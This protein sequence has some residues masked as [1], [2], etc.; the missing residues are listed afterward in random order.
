MNRISWQS[1]GILAAAVISA[2]PALANPAAGHVSSGTANI[3]LEGTLLT[4][5]QD[6]ARAIIDWG[7]FNIGSGETTVFEFNHTAGAGSAVLNRVSSGS[8]SIIDGI[9]RSTVGPNGPVGGTVMLLNPSGILFTPNAQVSVGN[10]VA[11]TLGLAESDFI[12][13]TTLHFSGSTAGIQNQGHLAAQGDI[14]LIAH[15]VQNSGSINAGGAAGLAAGTTVTLAQ[16]GNERLT[17]EAGTGNLTPIG[18]D[19][20]ASGQINAVAAELKAAGGNI[21]ALAINNGGIVRATSLVSQNGRISLRATDSANVT[22]GVVSS[23]GTLD[24]TGPRGADISVEGAS[25][26]LGGVVNAGDGAVDLTTAGNVTQA[27]D[28]HVTAAT[29]AI[30]PSWDASHF[31]LWLTIGA[32]ITVPGVFY[33]VNDF[34]S[35]GVG[36]TTL[37]ANFTT[38]GSQT[39][40]AVTLGADTTLASSGGGNIGLGAVTGGGHDLVVSTAGKTTFGGNA[41]GVG[42]LQTDGLGSS[43][44]DGAINAASVTLGDAATLNGQTVTTS[45]GQSYGAVILGVN[46]TLTDTG[47]K[48]ISLGSV[49][50]GG[51]DLMAVTAGKTTFGGNVAGVGTLLTDALGSSEVDGTVSATSV[52][53]ADTATLNGQTVTT[54]AGQSY[55]AVTLGAN[56]TLT[57]TGAKDISLGLVT[58]GGHNLAV[59][60]GGKTTFGGNI[61]GVG[62]L[63]TDAPGSSEADG[64]VSA[65]SVTLADTATLNGQTITT[66]AGQSYG[67]VTLGA[68]TILTDTGA[69]DISLGTVTGGGHNLTVTTGGKTTFGGN[70]AGVG[71]LQTD[72]PGSSEVDGTVSATT[73]TLADTVTLNGH[74]VTT[75]AG[76]SYGAVTLGANTALT[77]T[78]AKDISLGTV[79]GGGHNLTVT[80]G[81][82]TTFVGNTAGVGVLRT[83][84]PGSSEVD[85]TVNAASVMLA[86]TTT[87]NGQNVTTSAGQNYGAVTLGDDTTLTDTGT[88]DISLGTV[89][90]GGHDLT[91]TTSGKTIF[92]GNVADVGRLTT[93]APGSS[94]V[95]GTIYA[96][97]L[98]LEDPATLNGQIINTRSGGQY[99]AAV[100]LGANTTLTSIG[101]SIRLGTVTGGGYDLTVFTANHRKAIFGGNVAGVGALRTS[102]LGP[103]EVNGTISATSVTFANTAT[104]NGQTVTTSAGQ[105]YEAVT[106]GANTTLIDTGAKDIS[107]GTVT[108]V[109]HNLT[110][111]TAGGTILNGAVNG[112][113]ALTTDAGVAD[114]VTVNNVISANK[115]TFNDANINLNGGSITTTS[116]NGQDGSQTYKGALSLG[117]DT[118]LTGTAMLFG[119]LATVSGGNHDFTLHNRG[120][121]T[122]N[123]TVDG[124]HVFTASGTGKLTVGAT[125]SAFSVNDKEATRF[126]ASG[127]SANPSVLTLGGG[128]SYSGALR[129][130]GN[131]VLADDASGNL[132]FES[133]IDGPHVFEANTRGNEIFKGI[134]GSKAALTGLITDS[135]AAPATQQTGGHVE[136]N[137]G[138][139][140][141]HPSV[142]TIGAQTYF[143]GVVEGADTFLATDLKSGGIIFYDSIQANGYSLTLIN[144]FGF[145]PVNQTVSDLA[146]EVDR[147]FLSTIIPQVKKG[148]AG[149]TQATSAA[150]VT[151]PG[152]LMRTSDI[153][154]ASTSINF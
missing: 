99:Y 4:I 111:N 56:T 20:S 11:T 10:F 83:D 1:L 103:T 79:T 149:H 2:S 32:N 78:G 8:P 133:T 152:T 27:A 130:G 129:L 74:T 25:L 65:T 9:L 88:K 117:A 85:G 14:F 89:N 23:T 141:Q 112:V 37:N 124:V 29:L 34:V 132:V 42:A 51:Y 109:G 153:E 67:A 41:T 137:M 147:R 26:Q 98:S 35:D 82:K 47:A 54:S 140:T 31:N 108:G 15:T 94:E 151:L 66:S 123:G 48:N 28:T 76:Q 91:V 128:Q 55:G 150:A 60:T 126:N 16:S 145:N 131:T 114:S 64:T 125:V 21:Y 101:G 58:G 93:D 139:S 3:T 119:N 22:K 5:R 81:G 59:T 71:A 102:W 96:E 107:V 72:A 7:S 142:R 38:S 18:V 49:T 135:H 33:Q 90:G 45:S 95:D 106:L 19:N 39:Y 50:G 113:G 63:L 121:A 100:T 116:G 36:G 154:T 53:L 17:V 75:S 12:N 136:L 44:V 69:K 146:F 105:S 61:A 68:N 80:T 127:S 13:N 40:A 122:L 143:D 52:T 92:V 148:Q 77:D 110:I 115:V 73:V 86:D 97:F 134:I 138:G 24:V 6:S 144:D 57:D 87:L 118:I 30:G 43:E 70:I 84:A 62:A 46:T 104:L 120:S